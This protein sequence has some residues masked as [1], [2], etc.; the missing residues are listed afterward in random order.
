MFDLKIIHTY[1]YMIFNSYTIIHTIYIVIHLIN[2]YNA[3][4][5]KVKENSMLNNFH[6][7]FCFEN[8]IT[9]ENMYID[10]NCVSRWMYVC[11]NISLIQ[12]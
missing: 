5:L 6:L 4:I 12:R 1:T 10:L 11:T 3:L 9:H 7:F 2:L 8:P